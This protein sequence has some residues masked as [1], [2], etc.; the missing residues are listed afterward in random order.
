[1]PIRINLL[2]E[3]QAA[4]ESRRK[5]P[6][7]RVAL[8]AISLIL[9]VVLW[10]SMLQLKILSAKSDLDSVEIKWKSIEKNY[11][12]AVDFQR[13]GIEA[14]QKL[15]ALRQMTTNRFLWATVLN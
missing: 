3:A 11:Q 7:K 14:E 13:R 6:V 15:S 8:A 4:E 5:D 10:A 9:V 12:E 1:M 2:A